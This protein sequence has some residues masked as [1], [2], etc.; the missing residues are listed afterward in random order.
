MTDGE[1]IS[2]RRLRKRVVVFVG[3]VFVALGIDQV[4]KALAQT[5]LADNHT[6][7]LLPGLLSLR[8]IHNPGASL[9]LGSQYTWVLSLVAIAACLAFIVL[10][11]RTDSMAWT[12]VLALAFSGSAGNLTDR[13]V[14]ANSFLD[15]RV[16]DFLDYGWSIGN[17]ADI[18]L[19]VA[20]VVIVFFIIM[21]KPFRSPS[22]TAQDEKVQDARL[23]TAR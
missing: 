3:F 18:Y 23:E 2:S 21:G 12:I 15:G 8:L 22:L 14:N 4:T 5:L 13:L 17:I 16:V 11:M 1:N 20:A 6:R 7:V 19:C 9:G 10:F